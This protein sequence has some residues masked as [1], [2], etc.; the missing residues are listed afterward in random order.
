M[1]E[2]ASPGYLPNE[3]YLMIDKWP[4]P[5][6]SEFKNWV[7]KTF[8]E[9]DMSMNKTTCPLKR[10]QIFLANFI[11]NPLSPYRGVLLYHGLGTG[12]TRTSIAIAEALSLSR[13]IVVM[14]PASL[15]PNYINEI[16]S[17]GNDIYKTSHHW[18][19]GSK[20]YIDDSKPPN[21]DS[22]KES[23]KQEIKDEI[24]RMVQDRYEFMHYNGN[25]KIPSRDYFENKVVIIDEVHNFIS[26][27]KE[28]KSSRRKLYE[29]LMHTTDLKLIG[30]SGTP[31]INEPYELAFITNLLSGNI[32]VYQIEYN[33]KD[34]V[35]QTDLKNHLEIDHVEFEN[36]KTKNL[37]KIVLTPLGFQRVSPE[38]YFVR[39]NENDERTNEE[40]MRDIVDEL[41][42]KYDNI[43]AKLLKSTIDVE[44][45]PTD[46]KTFNKLFIKQNSDEYDDLSLINTQVLSR[47]VQGLISFY[48]S[49]DD[50]LPRVKKIKVEHLELP[51]HMFNKYQTI[52]QKEKSKEI[53]QQKIVQKQSTKIPSTFK[54]FSRV[55][56][57]F[58]FPNEIERPYPDQFKNE[59]KSEDYDNAKKLALAS[60]KRSDVLM[61]DALKNHGMKYHT[62][63]QNVKKSKGPVLIY[64]QFKEVEGL[65]I[66]S[67]VLEA[68][69]V[70]P[71]MCGNTN[72]S[73][74]KEKEECSLNLRSS[75]DPD[76]YYFNFGNKRF[77]SV[78][79]NI[80]NSNYELLPLHILEQVKEIHKRKNVDIE[81]RNKYG[82]IIKFI[83]ISPSGAEGISL[84]NVRQVHILEPY[85]NPIRNKQVIG[86]AVRLNSHIDLDES[87]RNVQVY[88]Y[89]MQFS[90]SQRKTTIAKIDNFLT[91]DE[92]IYKIAERKNKLILQI[93][94]VLRSAS[95]D[96][97]KKCFKLPKNFGPHAYKFQD[98]VYETLDNIYMNKI[99]KISKNAN[100]NFIENLETKNKLYYDAQTG[101]VFDPLKYEANPSDLDVIGKIDFDEDQN[102]KIFFI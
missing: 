99:K 10:H 38:T 13:K 11:G 66:L 40:R 51:E 58:S 32:K 72:K 90:E 67:F 101:L 31:L 29:Y 47:R 34:V 5:N 84:K 2:S 37:I 20:W 33:K 94:S 83:L 64:S 56:L 89:I 23:Q 30:L 35:D 97:E 42:Q 46:K 70:L 95:I 61:G 60:I 63:M 9:S 62:L 76:N 28:E 1:S 78:L 75:S 49:N 74:E 68:H 71:L 55:L 4:L 87:E 41:N 52:R 53:E 91:T 39:L 100:L 79:L 26:A 86:R 81:R 36:K 59:D 82:E 73:E 17:C 7:A 45:L 21:F 88:M 16:L 43:N 19:K 54:V 12:K 80:F 92:I 69:N 44:L 85:W 8:Q 93:E 18:K 57:L 25:P 65:K 96:C 102:P 24:E 6:N 3:K 98:V 50:N 15:E 48:E 27:V 22:L 14:L 77:D